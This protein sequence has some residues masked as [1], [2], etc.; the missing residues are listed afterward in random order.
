V[1]KDSMITDG[2]VIVLE[3]SLNVLCCPPG[4]IVGP[5][6]VIRES[7]ILTDSYIEAGAQIE[8]SIID[9]MTIIGQGAQ[10]R[11]NSRHGDLGSP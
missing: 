6:A 1:I 5:K 2:S 7:V 8:R 11:Q 3:R 10:V 9:K 4:V